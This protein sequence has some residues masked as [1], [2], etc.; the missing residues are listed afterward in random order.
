M[1]PAIG[2]LVR[3]KRGIDHMR[4]R[5]IRF[6]HTVSNVTDGRPASIHRQHLNGEPGRSEL[7]TQNQYN[8]L[9]NRLY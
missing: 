4:N 9:R 6:V 3:V 5:G 7:G 1:H 2:L 8:R